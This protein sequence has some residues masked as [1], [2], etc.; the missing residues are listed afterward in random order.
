[1]Q[2]ARLPAMDPRMYGD[3]AGWWPLLSAPA[4]YAEEAEIYR[5]LLTEA[6][7]RPP[8]AVL[9]LGSGGGNNASHLKAPLQPPPVDL[10]PGMREVRR[11]LNPEGEH[12]QG[13]MRTVR[14]GR[15][16]GAVFVHDAINYMTTT[17]DLAQ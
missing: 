5:R 16:F 2:D 14:L 10:P 7:D 12:V 6:A 1:S 15:S 13:D 4:T 8:T 17:E 3:L 9:E 11:E